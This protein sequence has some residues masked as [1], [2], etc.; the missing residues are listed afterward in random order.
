VKSLLS[1]LPSQTAASGTHFTRTFIATR[2]LL[3]ALVLLV[4][5]LPLRAGQT[6]LRADWAA[7]YLAALRERGWHDVA[8][9]YLDGAAQDPLATPAFL[10]QLGYQR[11]T[12]QADLARQAVGDAQR[13]A[14][15]TAA[16]DGFQKFAAEQT[17][18][19][20]QLQALA[21]AGNLFT[22]QALYATSKAEKL[23]EA[24]HRQR[25]RLQNSARGFLER[26]QLSLQNLLQ[27]CDNK[28]KSLPKAAQLQKA[29]LP[30]N[31]RGQDPRAQSTRQQ[32]QAK[33]A[34]A[35]FLLAKLDFEKSRTYASDS[36]ARQIALETAAA[37]FAKLYQDYE[38]KLV[39]F[40]GRLYQA[41]SYQAAGNFE[42][43]LECYRDIV[44]QPPIANQDFRRLVAR[45]YRYRAEC[46]LRVDAPDKAIKEC[47]E[48]LDASRGSE[49]SEPDWLAVSYRLASAY[50]AKAASSA[51][52]EVQKLRTEA[53]KLYREIAKIPGEFQRDARAKMTSTISGSDKPAVLKTFDEAFGA[54]KEALEQMNSAKLAA[55]LAKENN[56]DSVESLNEQ[57][58]AHQVA[59]L[60]YF[61]RALQLSDVQTDSEQ[62]VSARYYLCWLY[63]EDG[64]P[65]DAAVIGK[66]LARRY[67]E[68]RFAP[69]AA[70][71]ALA[72]YQQL[73][74]RAKQAGESTDFES[75]Q[76]AEVAELLA[77]RWPE[78][79]EAAAGL[80]LLINI[81]LLDDRLSD[82]SQLL[83]RLPPSSRGAAELRL[84]RALWT[85]YLNASRNARAGPDDAVMALK[86]QAGQ[87]LA[88]GYETLQV[89]S[90]ATSKVTSSEAIGVLY[91]AQ[92]LLAGG[93][94]LQ[95]VAV[96]ENRSIGPLSLIEEQSSATQSAEFVQMAYRA[97]LRAYVSVEPPERE[98][99]RAMMTALESTIGSE[100][101]S[102]HK[103][104]TI[105]V[106]LGLELQQQISALTAA[107]QADK[108]RGVAA[109]F[110]DL[111]TR[112]TRRAD[113]ANDW[114]VQ[115]WVANMNLQ[116]GKG[117][118]GKD[119]ARYYQQ[120]EVA[121]QTLLSK[122]DQD[123]KF[124]PSPIAVL[125]AKK[126]LADAQQAQRKY[127]AAFQ[128]YTSILRE[129]PNM[130]ELQQVVATALQQWGTE[131]N[132][133]EKIEKSIRG[134]MPQ[135][136][137]KNL[138]W[139]WLRLASIADQAKRKAEKK[140]ADDPSQA[141][142]I[143]TFENLFF[144]S[145]Y[146]VAQARFAA[147]KLATGADRQKQLRSARQSLESMKRLYPKLGGPQWQ[148][149]YGK[150]LEQ[151]EQVQ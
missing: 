12:T 120:A 57:A 148:G 84:G 107:G 53:R 78:S 17:D 22:E 27:Q 38:E 140:A 52:S 132:D 46:H 1:S 25:E 119:A 44:D 65:D 8:L 145:R 98:K 104:I 21:T 14:L 26:A 34:E 115:N 79:P 130:L 13:Q 62:L 40:Y 70:K 18:S 9:E 112:L 128:Q 69:V 141:R 41:R 58:G 77:V 80:N 76:L 101:K 137:K 121:Y 125:A 147:A 36:K 19:P 131:Q 136:N 60:Q 37:A 134:A 91:Y 110:E 83:E 117:L 39:G 59:A 96:L 51:G 135:T 116:L 86:R 7:D 68:S 92:F 6:P 133:A 102:Q 33:R 5:T 4:P 16:A 75:Q 49:L 3:V 64:R 139:G 113:S 114:K 72:A 73:Y 66:F 129:K 56:P 55:R 118:R 88:S 48:W 106:N 42:Q 54:G 20:R 30:K 105:Y 138:V 15:L 89:P 71:L 31:P 95:A 127:A 81:A 109:S 146:H 47:T 63:W 99:A 2:F 61:Q 93:E 100:D 97:A 94:P 108:A 29:A 103:L 124:A 123:P 85:R 74:N 82:A 90:K 35:K 144:Q 67:P 11:A 50:E 142:K 111:L 43:A 122:A 10:A 23:P 45:A 126:R 143:A 32:L 150:L 151:M 24:A 28:L 149:A 87:L